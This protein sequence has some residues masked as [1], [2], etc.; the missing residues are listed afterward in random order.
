[1]RSVVASNTQG[2]GRILAMAMI[3]AVLAIATFMSQRASISH[4]GKVEAS[5]DL[6]L[7][8]ISVVNPNLP[9]GLQFPGWGTVKDLRRLGYSEEEINRLWQSFPQNPSAYTRS[10]SLPDQWQ[11]PYGTILP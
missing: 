8:R 3:A 4:D 2:I 6:T 1:M 9:D 5:G 11:N 10:N 7:R